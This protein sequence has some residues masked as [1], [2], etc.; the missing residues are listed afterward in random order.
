[1]SLSEVT[2][3]LALKRDKRSEKDLFKDVRVFVQKAGDLL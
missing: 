2:Y 3:V 1:M